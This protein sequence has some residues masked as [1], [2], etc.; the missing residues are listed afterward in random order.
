MGLLSNQVFIVFEAVS[1]LLHDSN[2]EIVLGNPEFLHILK[3]FDIQRVNW[4]KV[5]K[6][7]ELF[8]NNQI[9]S[10]KTDNLVCGQLY[11]W[12]ISVIDHFRTLKEIN[13]EKMNYEQ[14][15]EKL[16]SKEA[17]VQ[18]YLEALDNIFEKQQAIEEEIK[19]INQK[20]LFL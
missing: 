16:V 19:N 13:K 2:L 3:S 18:N 8:E 10:E 9:T 7:L 4:A 1:I 11:L 6:I 20:L 15:E 12:V 17:K 14:A 5:N